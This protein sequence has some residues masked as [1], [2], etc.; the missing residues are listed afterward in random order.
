MKKPALR[1]GFFVLQKPCNRARALDAQCWGEHLTASNSVRSLQN[2][3]RSCRIEIIRTVIIVVALI[4]RIVFV[5]G[6]QA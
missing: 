2:W 4:I 6:K 5:K 3:I 1:A